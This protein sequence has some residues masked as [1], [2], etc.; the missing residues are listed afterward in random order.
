M[1]Q[2]ERSGLLYLVYSGPVTFSPG[3]TS[4]SG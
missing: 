4:V 3:G 2:C 1:I